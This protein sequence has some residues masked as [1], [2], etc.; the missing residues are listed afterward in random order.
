MVGL[1]VAVLVMVAGAPV[2]TWA[3]T[4]M[5]AIAPLF[6]TNGMDILLDPLPDPQDDPGP[7]ANAVPA[8]VMAHVHVVPVSPVGM[9]SMNVPLA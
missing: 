6:N 3:L 8:A 4:V 1:Y 7:P 2:A 9:V 5:V